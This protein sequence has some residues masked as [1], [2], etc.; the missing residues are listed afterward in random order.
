MTAV[1]LDARPRLVR[2]RA[3]QERLESRGNSLVETRRLASN[4]SPQVATARERAPVQP[5]RLRL[6]SLLQL[7]ADAVLLARRIKGAEEPSP[8]RADELFEPLPG[9]P[10]LGDIVAD[11]DEHHLDLLALD[12][13]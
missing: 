12:R 7:D 2:S 1:V 9:G 11:E 8:A 5:E 3:F 13:Y 4:S 6:V 10:H